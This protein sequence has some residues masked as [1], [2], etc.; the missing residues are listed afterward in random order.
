MAKITTRAYR[1]RAGATGS[2]SNFCA[3][4]CRRVFFGDPQCYNDCIACGSKTGLT[5]MRGR[6][7]GG[8]GTRTA[9][10]AGD[11]PRHGKKSNQGKGK[12][13]Y[14]KNRRHHRQH[15]RHNGGCGCGCGGN[16]GR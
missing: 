9:N 7:V 5:M 10:T 2:C 4:I 8:S 6:M 13:P 12:H 16:F 1:A 11:P 15:H 3:N 14:R